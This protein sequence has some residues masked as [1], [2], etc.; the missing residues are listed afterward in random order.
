MSYKKVKLSHISLKSLEYNHRYK[1]KI[2]YKVE[3]NIYKVLIDCSRKYDKSILEIINKN[4]I[5]DI[6]VKFKDHEKY[7]RDTQKYLK[8]IRKNKKISRELK[9]EILNELTC[10]IMNDLFTGEINTEK[11]EQA[12]SIID[13]TVAFLLEDP[14]AIKSMLKITTFDFYTYTHS[15]NVSTYALGFAMYLKLKEKDLNTIGLAAILHDIGK[16]K[17]SLDI[18][19]KNGTLTKKEFLK[20]KEHSSLGV[21]MLKKYGI[22]DSLVL[23]IIEQH[24]E[25]IDG[26]G[27]PKGLKGDEIIFFSRILTIADIFDA[28]TTRR[29][30]KEA[31]KTF[32]AFNIMYH[33]MKNELDLNL[34]KKFMQFMNQ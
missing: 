4:N 1:Y 9:S 27:Y 30:Y 8:K 16:K 12:K 14:V 7:E 34:L 19:N 33:H 21:E 32:E 15:I 20:V 28:L 2:Y 17:I 11:I 26:S 24:H 5:K 22:N 6:Y 3:D 25:K 13:D 31:L 23:N 18:I 29:S 10:D